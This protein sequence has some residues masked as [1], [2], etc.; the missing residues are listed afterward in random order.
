MV[1][2][3]IVNELERKLRATSQCAHGQPSTSPCRN[4]RTESDDHQRVGRLRWDAPLLLHGCERLEPLVGT[5]TWGALVGTLGVPPTIDGGG[6][7]APTLA[8]Y[9]LSGKW[10]VENEGVAP[11][12]EVEY[13]PAEVNKG[14]DPQLERAVQE[15]LKL[16]EQNPVR[17]VPRPAPINRVSMP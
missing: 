12:I 7:T 10:A 14:R 2:D 15:A 4:L 6:I 16:L 8:F 17:R 1:A 3:Y 9:D 13:T 11:D 5:R